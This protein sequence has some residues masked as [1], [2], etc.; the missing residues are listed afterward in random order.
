VAPLWQVNLPSAR[1]RNGTIPKCAF[2]PRGSSALMALL[3]LFTDGEE[4]EGDT[5]RAAREQSATMRLF[6]VGVGSKEGSLI[7]IRDSDGNTT[8]VK[9]TKDRVVKSRL[10]EERLREIAETT[11]GFYLH[12]QRGTADMDELVRRGITQLKDKEG[13][14]RM[15]REPIERYQWPLSLAI[16]LIAATLLINERRQKKEG[17]RFSNGRQVAIRI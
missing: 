4:L 1:H 5:V 17:V 2:L 3:I 7:P 14:E 11:G 6:T 8:F 9:D 10:D 16:I 12:L 13:T 15:S